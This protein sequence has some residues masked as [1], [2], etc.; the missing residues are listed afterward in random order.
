MLQCEIAVSICF[1]IAEI[2]VFT[3]I[4]DA[5][6]SLI[7]HGGNYGGR[8]GRGGPVIVYPIRRNARERFEREGRFVSALRYR[9]A[10][11]VVHPNVIARAPYERN[12]IPVRLVESGACDSGVRYAGQHDLPL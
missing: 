5:S 12:G 9:G 3:E 4:H 6:C 7:L 2:A 10:L 1:R 11:R 8:G